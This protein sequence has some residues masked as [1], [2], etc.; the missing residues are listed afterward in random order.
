MGGGLQAAEKR[1]EEEREYIAVESEDLRQETLNPLEDAAQ[2]K[3]LEVS[4]QREAGLTTRLSIA[5][6][7]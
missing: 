5:R 1:T 3:H 4:F 7:R 2:T 6:N